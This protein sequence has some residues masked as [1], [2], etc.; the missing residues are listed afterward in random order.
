VTSQG[1]DELP[2]ELRAFLHSC[3][4]SIA[5]AELL[6]ALR[7]SDQ[8][9]TAREAAKEL[10]APVAL[11]RQDLETLV[12]R[13]LLSTRIGEEMAFRYQPRSSDLARYCDLL[14]EHYASSRHAVLA[15]ITGRPRL[16]AKRFAD[17]FKLR[18]PED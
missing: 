4:E 9:W 13:G 16:S 11:V 2:P 3:I 18:E 15:F 6:L 14:A 17:A 7:R 10:G 1:P 8:I 5:Q 12:A